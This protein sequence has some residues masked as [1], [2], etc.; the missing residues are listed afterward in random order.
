MSAQAHNLNTKHPHSNKEDYR[1]PEVLYRALNTTYGPFTL[2]AAASEENSLA[3]THFTEADDGLTK[4]WTGVVWCN[5]PY[6]AN[7]T[8]KWVQKA[9]EEVQAGNAKRVVMLIPAYNTDS[10]CFH[11]FVLPFASTILFVR[12]RLKFGGPYSF[13]T[14]RFGSMVV[15]FEVSGEQ[16]T[17]GG[18]TREGV[19]YH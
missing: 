15:V 5:P 2:D 17:I 19:M 1:T 13:T 3:Q 11:E 10:V 18:I 6:G 16:R 12:G 14:A 8:G 4:Q 7:K 9:V